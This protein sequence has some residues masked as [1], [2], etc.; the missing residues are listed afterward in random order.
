MMLT[1]LSLQPPQSAQGAR[2]S[3]Q[4]KEFSA[5]RRLEISS[6]DPNGSLLN[7]AVAVHLEQVDHADTFSDGD[8]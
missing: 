2:H 1:G 7:E 4:I 3:T 6:D 5:I 8:Q